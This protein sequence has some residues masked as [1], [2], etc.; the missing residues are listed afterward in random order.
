VN[1]TCKQCGGNFYDHT[2]R[3]KA[4]DHADMWN[5]IRRYDK[6]LFNAT[7]PPFIGIHGDKIRDNREQESLFD[8]ET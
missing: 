2:G 8:D 4:K 1:F 3:V 7:E 5:V 6:T